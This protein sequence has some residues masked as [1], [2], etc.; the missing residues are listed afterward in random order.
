MKALNSL[1]GKSEQ[2]IKGLGYFVWVILFLMCGSNVSWFA[3]AQ[4]P[5]ARKGKDTNS[6]IP[7]GEAP[8]SYASSLHEP[9]KKLD[10]GYEKFKMI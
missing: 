9:S 10:P 6:P 8:D 2:I 4:S 7:T 1:G 5:E 3:Q